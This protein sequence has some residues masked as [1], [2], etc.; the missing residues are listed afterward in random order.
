[1]RSLP[2]LVLSLSLLAGCSNS[3]DAP[4]ELRGELDRMQ[5]TYNDHGCFDACSPRQ[6]IAKGARVVLVAKGEDPEARYRGR[7]SAPGLVIE[8]EGLSCACHEDGGNGSSSSWSV[9][10][11]ETCYAPAVRHCARTFMLRADG[12]GPATLEVLGASD[13]VVDRIGLVV[14]RPARLEAIVKAS[15]PSGGTIRTIAASTDGSFVVDAP[16]TVDLEAKAF[17]DRGKE[18]RKGEDDVRFSTAQAELAVGAGSYMTTLRAPAVL[19][20]N[21]AGL[22]LTKPVVVR[23]VAPSPR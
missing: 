19:H 15:R 14:A 17:D 13:E 6:P 11:S 8:H 20:V 21:A 23:A 12:V 2:V 3:D 22:G 10:A 1:M 7:V 16:A 4:S 5:F 18:L 9:A